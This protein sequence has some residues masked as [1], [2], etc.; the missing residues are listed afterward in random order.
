MSVG[1]PMSTGS[2]PIIT[3]SGASE[4]TTR[5]CAT[6][7]TMPTFNPSSEPKRSRMVKASSRAWVGCSCLPSPPLTTQARTWRSMTR[8][9]PSWQ[10]RTT[11]RSASIASSVA[12]V[13]ASDSPFFVDELDAEKLMASADRRFAAISKLVRVRVDGSRKR[14][15]MVRPRKVG[16]F[17]ISRSFTSL[18]E[19]A[20]S[21]TS[22]ISVG[23]RSSMSMRLLCVPSM[24]YSPPIAL[25]KAAS[26]ALALGTRAAPTRPAPSA[27]KI[28]TLVRPS[29]GS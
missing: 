16:S 24:G 17:F 26:S 6:S 25:V 8:G 10:L 15:T 19:R 4:P 22:T 28:S 27:S 21:R 5:E 14:L 18:N 7:P 1:G 11:T 29:S 9:A 12:A 2:A 20:Q 13:S 23:V 3:S